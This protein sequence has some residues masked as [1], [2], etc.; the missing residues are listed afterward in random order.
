MQFRL[1]RPVTSQASH[2]GM[3]SSL[4]T[5]FPFLL[6]DDA[7]QARLSKRNNPL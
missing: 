4:G 6:L 3:K 5:R 1:Q 7:A 2:F